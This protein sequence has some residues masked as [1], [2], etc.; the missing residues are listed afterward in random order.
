MSDSGKNFGENKQVEIVKE[1]R[2][3][4]AHLLTKVPPYH[5]CA[6]L[7]GHSFRFEVRLRGAV[8]SELGWL[9]DFGDI[10]SVVRP[11][12]DI[13]DHNYLNDIEGLENPTSEIIAIW[14]W[15]RIKPSL[16]NLKEIVVHETCT[17]RCVYRG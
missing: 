6:R 14:L 4:A 9:I 15:D 13:L 17:A 12:V 10:S 1:Y 11:L 3:E 16:A 8:D 5:K 7:H 2:F